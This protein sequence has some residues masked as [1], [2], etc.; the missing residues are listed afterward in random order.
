[1]SGLRWSL[2]DLFS[3]SLMHFALWYRGAYPGGTTFS[4]ASS[5]STPA[6]DESPPG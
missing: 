1:M 5:P 6:D 3:T 4:I 2:L